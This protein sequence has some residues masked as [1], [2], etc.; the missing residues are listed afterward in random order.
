MASLVG[1]IGR[2]PVVA[3][4]A[5]AF[6][7]SWLGW[8]P[9]TLHARGQFP[10]ESPLLG[11]LGGVGPTLAAV[12]VLLSIGDKNGIQGLFAALFRAR[13]SWVWY[14]F[15]FGFWPV[16][17]A[18]VLALMTFSGQPTQQVGQSVWMSLFPVFLGMLISNVWEE[19]GWRGFALPRLQGALTDLD[20]ALRMGILWELW[21]LPLTLNPAS[22]MSQ[23]PWYGRVVFSLSL[24]VIYTW[25]Y[26]NTQRSLF[27]VSV[28]HAM[29][30][31]AAFLL[32]QLG[33]F[34]TSYP[35]IVGL[36]AA[37]A[38]AVVFACGPKQFGPVLESSRRETLGTKVS[39]TRAE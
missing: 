28:F 17:T 35:V 7:L 9:Q 26:R 14:A 20:I 32:F 22:P 36:T 6:L 27:F 1:T 10:F 37:A 13:A 19:I 4:Y 18:A 23:L 34:V 5:L 2:H 12:F 29:S 33:L 30:N 3:F 11:L 39:D 8:V 15:A 38:L 24:T 21:H 31:T 25:L 16:V